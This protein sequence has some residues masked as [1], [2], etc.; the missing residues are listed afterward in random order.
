MSCRVWFRVGPP[1]ERKKVEKTPKLAASGIIAAI[2]LGFSTIA[3]GFGKA[4]WFR[5]T[6]LGRSGH[7][8]EFL[9]DHRLPAN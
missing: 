6:G 4:E 5:G 1:V 9:F 8:Q 3:N 7:C 2:R